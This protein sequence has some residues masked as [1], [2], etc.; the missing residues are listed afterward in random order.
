MV[1]LRDITKENWKKCCQLKV[2]KE[3]ENFVATNAWSLAQSK[4][5][6]ECIPLAIYHDEDMVGFL[7]YCIDADDGEYWV[8]PLMI[9]RQH[10]RRGYAFEAM[11]FLLNI[12][13]A[14]K[15]HNKVYI[16]CRHDNLGAQI[17]YEKLGFKRT[18]EFDDQDVYMRLDY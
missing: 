13:T 4:F 7:M 10:Q 16:D 6:P 1:S 12:I 11:K 14:D 9:D 5:Q 18:D 15:S 3:Q 2:E 8:Y 17:L